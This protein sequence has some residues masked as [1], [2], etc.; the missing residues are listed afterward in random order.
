MAE[1]AYTVQNDADYWTSDKYA[2]IMER[3]VLGASDRVISGKLFP[4]GTIT[5]DYM[6][7]SGKNN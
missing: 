5:T 6:N 4:G 2:K 1:Q 7:S 3:R